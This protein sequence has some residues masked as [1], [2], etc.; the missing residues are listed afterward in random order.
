VPHF[1]AQDRAPFFFTFFHPGFFNLFGGTWVPVTNRNLSSPPL[2][3]CRPF[4]PSS[5]EMCHHSWALCSTCFCVIGWVVHEEG[6]D[7]PPPEDT[8]TTCALLSLSSVS[9]RKCP[10]VRSRFMK[11]PCVDHSYHMYLQ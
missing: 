3:A 11:M 6:I 7:E 4:R 1:E 9:L 10:A 8:C 5:R 2:P